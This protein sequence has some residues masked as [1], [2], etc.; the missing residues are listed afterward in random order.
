[1][2]RLLAWWLL[3]SSLVVTLLRWAVGAG[4]HGEA[5][6]REQYAGALPAPGAAA[7]RAAFDALGTCIACG[8]CD[9]AA[10][11][12]GAGLAS[13]L[14]SVVLVASRSVQDLVASADEL[15]RYDASSLAARE[16]DCPTRFPLRRLAALAR[17]FAGSG[18]T[19]PT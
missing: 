3:G 19:P 8:L 18:A 10:P 7:D 17:R 15:A 13:G 11:P 5:R 2:A 14:T 12:D 4:R 9:R 16:Q 1:V 6:F